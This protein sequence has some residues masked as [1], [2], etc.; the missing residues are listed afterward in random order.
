[1]NEKNPPYSHPNHLSPFPYGSRTGP[2]RVPWDYGSQHLSRPTRT[3]ARH[4]SRTAPVRV[5]IP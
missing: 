2:V 1:M 5:P 3:V 4:L